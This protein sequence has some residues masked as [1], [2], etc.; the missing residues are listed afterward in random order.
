MKELI[1]EINVA[2]EIEVL[3][4]EKNGILFMLGTIEDWDW[5][6]KF[7]YWDQITDIEEKIEFLKK[8]SINNDV[9]NKNITKE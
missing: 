5:A 6:S 8:N 3:E 2:E 9:K 7:Q 4:E 1:K